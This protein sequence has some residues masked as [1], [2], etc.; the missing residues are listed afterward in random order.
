[1]GPLAA[2]H[3]AAARPPQKI[4]VGPAC[5][6]AEIIASSERAEAVAGPACREGE[7][8]APARSDRFL[9]AGPKGQP[10]GDERG[11][12]RI[13]WV[14]PGAAEWDAARGPMPGAQTAR[15]PS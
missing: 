1:M 5:R 10:R 6:E 8:V 13:V 14:G 2:S 11:R 3:S 7:V 12:S 9:E 15:E 4:V